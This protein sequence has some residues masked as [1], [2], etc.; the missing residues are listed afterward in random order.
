[1]RSYYRY[2][3]RVCTK[4]EEDIPTVKRRERGDMWV[5]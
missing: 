2:K 3:E 1:M 5:Y 4:K